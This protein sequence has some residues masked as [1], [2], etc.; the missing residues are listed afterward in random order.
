MWQKVQDLRLRTAY[1]EHSAA[2]KF[3]RHVLAILFLSAEHIAP[4]MYEMRKLRTHTELIQLLDYV[5]AT[6]LS[7]SMWDVNAWSI[8]SRAIRTNNDVDGWHHQMNSCAGHCKLHFY[9]LLKFLHEEAKLVPLY[10]CLVSEGKL[11]AGWLRV[12]TVTS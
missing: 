5:E 8:F 2:Y 11:Q 6:W 3:I 10:A 4:T 1:V 9:S 7:S 12:T